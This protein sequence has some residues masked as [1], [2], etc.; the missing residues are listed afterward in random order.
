VEQAV[1]QDLLALADRVRPGKLVLAAL[2]RKLAR[3]LD[4]RGD[5]EPASQTAKAV[6]T[7]RITMNQLTSGEEHDP[8]R[9]Q[10]LAA[11]LGTP[12]AGG[13]AVSPEVRYPKVTRPADLGPGGGEDR[14]S[15]G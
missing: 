12:T 10:Q 11:I 2:A 8:D 5:E 15:T 3:V 14:D 1:E 7:L 13:S 6:D 4:K 9:E